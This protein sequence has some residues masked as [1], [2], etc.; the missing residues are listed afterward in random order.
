VSGIP[1]DISLHVVPLNITGGLGIGLSGGLVVDAGLDDIHIGLDPIDIKLEPLDI[2]I[3][4][5]DIKIEP[6]RISLDPIK[7]DLGLDNINVCLSLAL[8][9]LPRMQLHFPTKYDFGFS[10]FGCQIFGFSI[11]GESSFVTEDNPPRVFR[12]VEPE[13]RRDFVGALVPGRKEPPF[14]V[15]LP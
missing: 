3:E 6:L 7:I 5:L 14:K 13:Y 12:K 9:Q 15:E 4:P 11:C 8:T 10:M 1:N 2:K